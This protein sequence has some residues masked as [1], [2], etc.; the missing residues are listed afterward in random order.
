MVIDF[1]KLI[2][3][4]CLQYTNILLYGLNSRYYPFAKHCALSKWLKYYQ[5][6]SIFIIMC[7]TK[8]LKMSRYDTLSLSILV[9][10]H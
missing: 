5:L 7:L 9:L 6:R 10:A 4:I 8:H 3:F 2:M 1:L